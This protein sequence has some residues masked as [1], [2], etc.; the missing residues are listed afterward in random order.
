[1]SARTVGTIHRMTPEKLAEAAMENM[2]R[3]HAYSVGID[4]TGKVYVDLPQ[5]MSAADMIMTCRRSTDPDLLTE[6]IRDEMN[7]RAQALATRKKA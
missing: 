1:M 7:R 2:G 6:E 3:K 5:N 4:W